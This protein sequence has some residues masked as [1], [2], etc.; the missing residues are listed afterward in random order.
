MIC[1]KELRRG[2]ER[3]YTRRGIVVAFEFFKAIKCVCM[4]V[5]SSVKLVKQPQ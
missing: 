1:M 4:M 3:K 2:C 5:S